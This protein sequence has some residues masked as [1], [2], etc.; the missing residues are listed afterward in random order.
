MPRPTEFKDEEYDRKFAEFK[1]MRARAKA[2]RANT[3]S[4]NPKRT[5]N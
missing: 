5:N 1:A 3:D 4:E 2:E